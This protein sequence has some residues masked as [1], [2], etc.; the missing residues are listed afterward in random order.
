[1]SQRTFRPGGTLALHRQRHDTAGRAR[2]AG[3]KCTIAEVKRR[4]YP[5]TIGGS[6]RRAGRI[7]MAL[8]LWMVLAGLW[9]LLV[10]QVLLRPLLPIDETRYLAVAWEMY[11]SGDAFHPTRNFATYTHKPP[12]LF[13]L[14]DL[15][16]LIV[17]VS[18]TAARLVGPACAVAAVWMTARLAR[19]LWPDAPGVDLRAALVMTGF[20]VFVLYGSATMFDALLTLPVVA[21]VGLLW[22]IGQGHD[23]PRLWALFGL[24]LAVGIY[25]KGPVIAVYLLPPLMLMRLWAPQV[26]TWK[27]G[28][29]GMVLALAAAVAVVAVWLVPALLTG[30]AAFRHE[31]L[32]TQTADRVTGGMAHDRPVWFL[33]ML[34]PLLLFPFGWSWRLWPQ[35]VQAA[36]ADAAGRLCAI[37]A[38]SALVLFSAI[39]GKQAHYLIPAFPAV[40]LLV[41][42]AI[43]P[44]DRVQGR[45]GAAAFVLPLGLG[46]TALAAAAGLVPVGVSAL[47][48][49]AGG[50]ALFGVACL[51]VGVVSWRQPFLA[52]QVTAGAG[53][54]LSLHLL[55]A[56][57]GLS[58]A[59]DAR[60]LA[61][62]VAAAPAVAVA[63]MPYNAEFNFA[64]RLRRA[65]DLPSD[66]LALTRWALDHPDGLILGPVGKTPIAVPP[67][68]MIR[69]NGRDIG[70]WPAKALIFRGSG[71]AG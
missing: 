34:L 9:V 43:G 64:A 65:V 22:R 7:G 21:G 23:R 51:A 33:V 26:P 14:V 52:G 59:Y 60:R 69:Y 6:C 30:D 58:E 29:R 39:S 25:A 49:H 46:A 63:G 54:A 53:L 18:E 32:W 44:A 35:A 62:R 61:A 11:L 13:W 40:A 4:D 3:R 70:L 20:T 42:R 67:Q 2:V 68:E 55:V 17:G 27:G 16:W 1:M 31:L 50:L 24:A 19:R 28:L 8:R 41:A 48:G 57:T 10:A 71:R 5:G 38:L 37:W 56:G 36:R 47:A 66:A 15:V 45:F 12:L